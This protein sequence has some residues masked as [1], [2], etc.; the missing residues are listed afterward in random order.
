MSKTGL[1][2]LFLYASGLAGAF[3]RGPIIGLA[4]YLFVFFTQ[5]SWARSLGQE[6][7]SFYAAVIAFIAM[8][9]YKAQGKQ[10]IRPRKPQFKW[11]ILIVINM[12]IVS[13]FAVDPKS[14]HEAVMD[15][16]KLMVL[17]YLI[18]ES[19][20][21]RF[22]YKLI[23][24]MMLWGNYLFGWLAYTEGKMVAGRLENI[25]A[26]GIKNSNHLAGHMIMM[27]P[28]I[29]NLVL[30]GKWKE[31]ILI[32]LASPFILNAI[33]LCNSRGA[34]LGIILS[35]ILYVVL[36]PNKMKPRIIFLALLGVSLIFLLAN[37]QVIN[38]FNTIQTYEEDA[39]ATNRLK[40]WA[41][42]L[43]L[44]GD[45]PFGAGGGG[46]TF[47]SPIYIPDIVGHHG[48]NNRSVHNTWLMMLTD[49][50]IQGLLLLLIFYLSTFWGILKTIK[51]AKKNGDI[52]YYFESLAIL[53]GLIAGL[54]AA[55]FGNRIYAETLYWFCALSNVLNNLYEQELKETKASL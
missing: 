52:F 6:R 45:Y 31:K 18:I 24:W 33:M 44:S 13:I 28:F 26:P 48:D 50:G 14:S 4:T 15:F 19:I 37:E 29:G 17:Y 51:I 43:T 25:G 9:V 38:R 20:D 39:S 47:L 35:G 22:H 7:W 40:S 12:L 46:F 32:I 42:A 53:T 34:F 49:W 30:F 41:A 21:S 54:L 11:L 55:T 36:T 23:Q 8:L 1:V 10:K 3:I 5:E 2:W 27:I 16:L